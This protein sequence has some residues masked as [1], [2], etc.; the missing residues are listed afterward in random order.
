[1]WPSECDIWKCP[2]LH[3]KGGESVH[4]KYIGRITR[5]V[6]SDMDD[7]QDPANFADATGPLPPPAAPLLRDVICTGPYG[8]RGPT[9]ASW[10]TP[11]MRHL[12][13]EQPSTYPVDFRLDGLEHLTVS[14]DVLRTRGFYMK[15]IV[16]KLTITDGPGCSALDIPDTRM[17]CS[18]LDIPDTYAA[19]VVAC[20]LRW[21]SRLEIRTTFAKIEQGLLENIFEICRHGEMDQLLGIRRHRPCLVFPEN[22]VLV[23][24]ECL[25]PMDDIHFVTPVGWRRPFLG[26]VCMIRY[27]HFKTDLPVTMEP[28]HF[29]P[30]QWQILLPPPPP[31]QRY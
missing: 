14:V 1:M 21:I 10:N 22:V 29:E 23:M 27:K 8:D 19:R 31:P 28:I 16:R 9:F 25:R 5:V 18:A 20:E 3:S 15:G 17:G 11:P 6:L 7:I 24:Q 30:R 26:V 4:R 12:T 13:L 2:F